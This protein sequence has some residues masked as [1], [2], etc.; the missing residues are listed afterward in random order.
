LTHID[1]LEKNWLISSISKFVRSWLRVWDYNA[2]QRPNYFIAISH[3]VAERIKKYYN[4]DASVIYPPVDALSLRGATSP[5]PLAEAEK[6]RSNPVSI[7]FTTKLQN[8][9]RAANSASSSASLG[10]PTSR[11]NTKYFLLISR[12]RPYKKVDLA[13][14][15]F[16]KLKLPLKIVGIGEEEQK[17]KQTAKSNVEFLGS[18]SEVKKIKLLSNCQALIHPQE[19]DFGLTPIEAATFGKPVIAFRAGGA[20]E[21]VI[22]NVTGQFFNDQCW[23]SLA[24]AVIKFKPEKFDSSKI[25][26]H[27]KKFS[28]ER[29]KREMREF[30]EKMWEE[31]KK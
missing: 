22:E 31:Y 7:Q 28:K 3:A 9:S 18:A 16:N 27:A 5:E 21:T 23:E 10:A 17:L 13:I 26:E 4:R 1:R 6:R 15:A 20:L 19:E 29:F 8:L 14:Q 12:L 2:S 24:D 30:V 25:K 11:S